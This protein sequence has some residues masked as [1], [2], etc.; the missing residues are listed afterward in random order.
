M[1]G[2]SK[3]KGQERGLWYEIKVLEV[4]IKLLKEQGEDTKWLEDILRA[5]K[6]FNPKTYDK[7][8]NRQ[9]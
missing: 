2:K 7:W 8:L 1:G 6:K 3:M 5:Y 9:A 4:Q